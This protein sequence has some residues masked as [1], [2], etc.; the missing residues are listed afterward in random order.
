MS[1]RLARNGKERI[2]EIKHVIDHYR[3]ACQMR[4]RSK[5][6]VDYKVDGPKLWRMFA[7]E[8][9]RPVLA[10]ILGDYIDRYFSA[11]CLERSKI[12]LAYILWSWEQET[13]ARKQWRT[14]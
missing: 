5:G 1:R 13:E 2:P 12:S 4:T 14:A 11:R 10:W 9:E 6:W 7:R 8:P 3:Q